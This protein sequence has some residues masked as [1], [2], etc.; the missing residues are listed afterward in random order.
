MQREGWSFWWMMC[1]RSHLLCRGLR[2]I[3]AWHTDLG[4][5]GSRHLRRNLPARLVS[6]PFANYHLPCRSIY[7]QRN[8]PSK[9]SNS[10]FIWNLRLDYATGY[11]SSHI[12]GYTRLLRGKRK[13]PASGQ[14]GCKSSIN[15]VPAALRNSPLG[16][17]ASAGEPLSPEIERQVLRPLKVLPYPGLGCHLRRQSLF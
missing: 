3:T 13:C 15:E 11:F 2:R 9:S 8:V 6:T 1:E 16:R 12:R 14:C 10:G 17:L 7:S 5:L 4:G